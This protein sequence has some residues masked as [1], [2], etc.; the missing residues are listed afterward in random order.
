MTIQNC[1]ETLKGNY[2]EAKQ[3]LMNDKLIERFILKFPADDSITIL[4]EA[5]KA[6]DH[7]ESFR[8]AHTLKGV[9]ANLAFTELE[10]AAS[11]LTEQLRNSKDPADPVLFENV[12]TAYNLVIN[13]LKQYEA[14]K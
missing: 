14:E 4:R 5:V 7:D 2:E 10:K 12:E 3:R 11:E 9:A 8:G 1:Y 13:T 6:G